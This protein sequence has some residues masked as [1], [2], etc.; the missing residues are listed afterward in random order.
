[1]RNRMASLLPLVLAAACN[2]TTTGDRGEVTFTPDDCGQSFCSLDFDLAAGASMDVEIDA[3]SPDLDPAR[4]NLYAANGGV[5]VVVPI[6]SSGAS[7]WR[8][9]G[10][11]AGRTSLIVVD[12]RGVHIDVTDLE[13][14]RPSRL[15]LSLQHGPAVE[16]GGTPFGFEVWTVG[17]ASWV[18]FH[19]R[20]LDFAGGEMMGKLDLDVDLD[21]DLFA[22]LDP[23]A[24]L[25]L[26]EL[27]IRPM[28]PGDYTASFYDAH[29]LVLDVVLEVR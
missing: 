15:G 23:A 24:R 17:A 29:G 13:V 28:A 11:D 5:A 18:D 10:V 1:M 27:A 3:L 21:A 20:P 2:V 14:R 9:I 4:L 22:A 25:G 7:R 12:H 8:V 19:V 16:H 6:V 26:G